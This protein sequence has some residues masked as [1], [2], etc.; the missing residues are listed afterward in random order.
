MELSCSEIEA[1]VEEDVPPGTV[2]EI[3]TNL[4]GTGDTGSGDGGSDPG[5]GT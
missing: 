3:N 1:I 2:A 5:P 4:P